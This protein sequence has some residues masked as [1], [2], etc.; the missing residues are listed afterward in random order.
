MSCC[1]NGSW[2]YLKQPADYIAKGTVSELTNKLPVY[3]V[4]SGSKALII[5]PEVFCWEGRLKGICDHFAGQGYY[6]IMPDIMRG[7]KMN[8]PENTDATAYLKKWTVWSNIEPDVAAVFKHIA[9]KGISEIGSVGFCWGGWTIFRA[10][11]A[12]FP[13]K[14]GAICHPSVRLEGYAGS[15]E[16]T[17]AGKVKCP[18][19][20]ASSRNDPENIKEGGACALAL[21]E[22][23]PA[24]EIKSY[25][26]VDH[27][28]VSRGD[29]SDP[30][31]AAAVKAALAQT[32][33]FLTKNMQ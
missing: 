20:F 9:D 18:M 23:F 33:A 24:S 19:M 8:N 5:F 21:Q 3:E 28:W 4:G 26:D 14:C 15:D 6:V 32:D 1:P 27:G 29:V 13:L 12:G 10:S 7:D 17:L 31:V 11:A 25:G 16:V 2:P 22:K 30:V